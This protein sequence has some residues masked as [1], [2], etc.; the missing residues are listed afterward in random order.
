MALKKGVCKNFGNCNLADN[1][2]IQEVD[3]SEFRCQECGKE[4]YEYKEPPKPFP[5]KIILIIIAAIIIIGGGILAYFGLIKDRPLPLVES[6]LLSLN[7]EVI[8]L[9]VGESDTLTATVVT[10]PADAVVSV[11]YMSE[12]GNIAQVGDNGVV[13]AISKGDANIM[14]VAKMENG[15][16]DT[17]LVKVTIKESP[18][19]TVPSPQP[20]K[21]EGKGGNNGSIQGGYSVSKSYGTYN[22]GWGL[23]KGAME[24][25]K[26]KDGIW[27]E[28]KVTQEYT[29]DLKDGRGSTL[30]VQ[31]GDVIVNPKFKNGIFMLQGELHRTDGTRRVL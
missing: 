25:G 8:P 16:A 21:N 19:D 17:V 29:I 10:H 24:D 20:N 2:E 1:N 28:I 6:V 30:K 15:V 12:N 26:P 31:R 13:R 14:V 4:L 11:F 9:Y 7:K 18:L 3:S 5:L 22:L 23:Y 27:G